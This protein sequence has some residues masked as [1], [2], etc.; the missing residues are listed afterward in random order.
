MNVSKAAY[1]A[2]VSVS[3]T[4]LSCGVNTSAKPSS[5]KCAAAANY[6]G[7]LAMPIHPNEPSCQAIS[8]QVSTI[9][10]NDGSRLSECNAFNRAPAPK[11]GQWAWRATS[12]PSRPCGDGRHSTR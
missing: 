5:G 6:D 9:S 3:V 2:A 7:R 8:I 10:G 12:S 4:P 11:V 1:K